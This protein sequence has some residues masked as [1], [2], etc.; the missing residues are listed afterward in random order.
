M[1]FNYTLSMSD[2][3]TV[4]GGSGAVGF[5]GTAF[6]TNH[7]FSFNSPSSVTQDTHTAEVTADFALSGSVDARVGWL[8][9]KYT[10]RDWQQG[11]SSPQ[12]ESVYGDPFL[13]DTSR[14]H[15]WGNRLYNMGSYLAPGF[16]GHAIYLGLSY[17]FGG[18]S[19]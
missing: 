12:F 14:S 6:P 11:T 8:F 1:S 3:D 19:R 10:L 15:Q 18:E 5:D 16:T 7:E 2:L 4:Y 17:A 13:R 9:E